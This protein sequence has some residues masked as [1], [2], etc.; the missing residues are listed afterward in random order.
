MTPEK[1]KEV[2]EES[3]EAKEGDDSTQ[4]TSFSNAIY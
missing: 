1:H 2:V 3:G 4:L